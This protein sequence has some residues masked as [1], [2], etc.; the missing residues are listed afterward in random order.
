MPQIRKKL[1]KRKGKRKM[2]RKLI[3]CISMLAM[4][5]LACGLASATVLFE[6]NFDGTL[7][8]DITS[9]GWTCVEGSTFVSN[10]AVNGGLSMEKTADSVNQAVYTKALSST[11]AIPS[12]YKVTMT[13]TF[14]VPINGYVGLRMRDTSTSRWGIDILRTLAGDEYAVRAINSQWTTKP[15]GTFPNL[16]DVKMELSGVDAFFNYREHGTEEW[17][18]LGLMHDLPTNIADV[19]VLFYDYTPNTAGIGIDSIKIEAVPEPASML[20]LGSGLMG[21]AGFAIRRKK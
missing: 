21:L 19:Q 10:L 18:W 2:S 20:A 12:N 5:A 14:A 15:A 16:I 3:V 8:N 11:Y 4:L 17:R 6:E 13:G 1:F 7:Y 9:L